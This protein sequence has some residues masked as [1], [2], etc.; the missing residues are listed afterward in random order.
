MDFPVSLQE[1]TLL[2]HSV[3][4]P[5]MI[6]FRIAIPGKSKSSTVSSISMNIRALKPPI[7]GYEN[8]RQCAGNEQAP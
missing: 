6:L 8:M 3:P 7:F 1:E 2:N 5:V 4:T